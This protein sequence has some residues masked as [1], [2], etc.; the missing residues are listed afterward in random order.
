MKKRILAA[1]AL[2][3]LSLPVLAQEFEETM[4]TLPVMMSASDLNEENGFRYSGKFTYEGDA[5]IQYTGA[6]PKNATYKTQFGNEASRSCNVRISDK[7]NCY[8]QING[9]N[10]MDIKKPGVGFALLKGVRRFDGTDPLDPDTDKGGVRDGHEFIY[11]KTDPLDPSDDILFFELNIN[12]DTDKDVIKPEFFEQLDKVADV[13]LRNP[14]STAVVEGHADK[15]Q[16]SKRNY[17]ITLSQKRAQSVSRYL[18]NKGIG[19]DRIKAIGYGFDHPKAAN[20]PV[21]GNLANRRVEVYI[22]GVKTGKV[23]YVNPGE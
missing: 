1:A 10:T 17:N 12:F 21:S 8:F 13:M 3:L 23:N 5:E 4:G 2:A 18:Q 14:G 15:R 9:I 22:D 7:H 16:T 20:D 6:T 19:A 11:D